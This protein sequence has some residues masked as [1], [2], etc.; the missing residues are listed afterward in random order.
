M[1]YQLNATLCTA[2]LLGAACT[3]PAALAL[4][5]LQQGTPFTMDSRLGQ[6]RWTV[7]EVWSA[8]CPAC[9]DAVF[10]M[11]NFKR[12][13]PQADVFGIS[14]D[15]DEGREAGRA[16]AQQFA[17]RHQLGFTSYLG[18]SME[19]DSLLQRQAGE[20]LYGTPTVLIYDPVGKL[21]GMEA[22]AII[23]QDIIDFIEREKANTDPDS[24][25]VPE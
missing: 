16:M 13:Y 25:S 4:S 12:R 8:T 19:L 22:G 10:Y 15:E 23:S 11:N 18:S 21:K 7:V 1:T 24:A 14:V 9:P 17:R 20:T 2:L 6:G 3:P 5:D